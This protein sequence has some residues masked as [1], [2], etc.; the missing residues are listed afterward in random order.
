MIKILQLIR[1]DARHLW[2]SFLTFWVLLALFPMSETGSARA[3]RAIQDLLFGLGL[4]MAVFLLVVTAIQQ[5]SI[6]GDRQYWLMRPFTAWHL[7]AAK[8]LFLALF[9]NVPVLP[10]RPCC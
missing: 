9:I 3:M 4:P 6:M 7:M 1:K 10:C 8:A 2:P 5:E